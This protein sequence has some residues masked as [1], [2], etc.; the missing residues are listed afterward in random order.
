M[1][2]SQ[3]PTAGRS[4]VGILVVVCV[5][6]LAGIV[7]PASAAVPTPVVTG[8]LASD[9]RGSASRDYT[10]FATDLDLEGRGYVEEEF[11]ISGAANIYDAPNP[12]VG[13]GAGPVP[14][15]TAHIVSTGHL[16]KTRLVVRRPKIG[17]AH[18]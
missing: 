12:P 4:Q 8:P 6:A 2:S 9:P 13:I 15:P 14:A 18:V 10:F 3:R 11:F 1:P 17:R 16:Y 7:A 5:L